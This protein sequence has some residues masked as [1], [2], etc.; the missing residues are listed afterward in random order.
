M[1]KRTSQEISSWFQQYRYSHPFGGPNFPAFHVR[2]GQLAVVVL[3][4]LQATYLAHATQTFPW[5]MAYRD[6]D[7]NVWPRNALGL[8]LLCV[9]WRWPTPYVVCGNILLPRDSFC[10]TQHA[11]RVFQIYQTCELP[12]HPYIE[13]TA[14][15]NRPNSHPQPEVWLLS[16]ES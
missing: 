2:A 11:Q 8:L 1:L 13:G 3:S 9:W 14:N 15:S 16:Q 12:S 6:N 5:T 10:F 7:V 4:L